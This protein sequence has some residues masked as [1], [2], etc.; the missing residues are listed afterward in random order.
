MP[1][2]VVTVTKIP[3]AVSIM[4]ILAV[5]LTNLV[6]V[7]AFACTYDYGI[8]DVVTPWTSVID[9]GCSVHGYTVNWIGVAGLS[10]ISVSAAVLVRYAIRHRQKL[11]G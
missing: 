2:Q 4:A 5:G 3:Y 10:A 1:V 11:F 6:P 7:N 9:A 8:D